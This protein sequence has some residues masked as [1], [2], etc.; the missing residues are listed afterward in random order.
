MKLSRMENVVVPFSPMPMSA[1]TKK[2]QTLG[3]WERAF[4]LLHLPLG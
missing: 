1:I 2:Q 3:V 4:F